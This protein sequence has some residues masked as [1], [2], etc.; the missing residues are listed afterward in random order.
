[1]KVVILAGGM[2][3]RISE[4]T[5]VRPKALIEAGGKP[6]IWHVMKNYSNFGFNDFV[7]LVGYKGDLIRNYFANFW[8]NQSDVTFDLQSSSATLLHAR[9]LPWKVTIIETGIGTPTGS[10]IALIKNIVDD[11]FL[12]TYS[13]GIANVNIEKLIQFHNQNS[14]LV[15]LTAVQPPPRFG[16]LNL[17][18]SKVVE[19]EEKINT[20]SNWINGGFFVVSKDIF[21]IFPTKEFSFEYDILPV[22]AKNGDLNAFKHLDFWQPV[23]TIQDL[24]VLEQKI[25]QG[26]LPW[27]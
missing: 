3:S 14:S 9:Q 22:V 17:H 20:D 13:D 23:D 26:K 2:G 5:H 8:L 4:E 19:F 25:Q 7:I 10:R 6:L 24:S 11:D 27:M 21:T 16:A 1:M 12:L 18:G 15:T